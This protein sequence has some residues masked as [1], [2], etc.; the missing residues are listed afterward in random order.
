M[1][2]GL[3]TRRACVICGA[4]FEAVR[5]DARH[6]SPRCRQRAVRADRDLDLGVHARAV[7]HVAEQCAWRDEI[8]DRTLDRIRQVAN[9]W[10]RLVAQLEDQR[11]VRP[12]QNF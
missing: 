6:C 8:S 2:S 11:R 7:R 4:E 12:E 5:S 1:A 3:R 9:A 10:G